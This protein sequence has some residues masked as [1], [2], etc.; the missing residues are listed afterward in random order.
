MRMIQNQA[1]TAFIEQDHDAHIA[2]HINFMN[3]LN[4]DAM[5]QIAPLFQAHLA[6]HY[7]YKYFNEM[8]RMAGGQLIP[9]AQ[10]A[11]GEIPPEAEMMISQIAAQMPQ[12]QIMPPDEGGMD[13]EQEAFEREQAREDERVVREE[14]RKDMQLLADQERKEAEASGK[15][16]REERLAE[17]KQA[18][19]DRAQ[20]AKE[21]REAIAA[22]A[23]I[24]REEKVANAK[25]R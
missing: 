15:D 22:A 7:A 25:T 14:E 11:Q 21:K 8:N 18:R 23:K 9:P 13:F 24:K 12:I 4:E 19:E 1:A 2:V 6:E 5:E 3:G 10:L 16:E 17:A 20:R